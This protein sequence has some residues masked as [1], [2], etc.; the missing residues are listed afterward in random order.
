M[1]HVF[2]PGGDW[3][4]DGIPYTVEVVGYRVFKQY[5]DN[6]WFRTFDEMKESLIESGS[7]PESGTDYESELRD[8]I[9][10]LGG[11]PG[12]RSSISTLEK[13][14]AALEKEHENQG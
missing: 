8:K 12:G 4:R 5:L 14:L 2:K 9:K 11:K 6:G 1:I 3:I 7:M 13:Q 10:E